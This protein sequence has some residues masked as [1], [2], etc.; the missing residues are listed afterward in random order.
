VYFR[1]SRGSLYVVGRVGSRQ[2]S[3]GGLQ[4]P[5]AG[6]EDALKLNKRSVMV[7]RI[8]LLEFLE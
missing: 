4:F 1:I 7:C 5:Y 6:S 3:H 8:N 2:E